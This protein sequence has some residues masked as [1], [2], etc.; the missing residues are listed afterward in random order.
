MHKYQSGFGSHFATEAIPGT[1][2]NGQNSPQRH[3]LGLYTEQFSATAFTMPRHK[4][5][6]SW[7]YRI[8]PSVK[9]GCFK[10]IIRNKN[11]LSA[12]ILHETPPNAMRWDRLDELTHPADFIEGL[13]SL[14][15][16]GD[17]TSMAG[18]AI[19]IYR[20]NK[21]MEKFFYNSDGEMV[22]VPESGRLLIRT[23]MGNLEIEPLEIVVIPR[24]IKFQVLLLDKRID[25]NSYGYVCENYGAPFQ[26][27]DLGPIGA[28]GLANPR[29]FEY[30]VASFEDLAG[31]F[32]LTCKL[33]GELWETHIK[34]SPFDV[35]AWHGN[36]SPYKYDLRKYNTIGSISFDHPDPSI[37]TVLTSPTDTPGMANIDFVIFPPRWMVAENT[38]RPPWYHRNVMSEFMGL[39][40]GQYDAKPNGFVTGGSSIHNRMVPHGPDSEAAI[41]A[42][43]EVLEPKHYENTMAFMFESSKTWKVTEFALHDKS[44]QDSYMECWQDIP[45]LFVG[46]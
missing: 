44:Y 27:P 18:A 11:F 5:I 46:A 39:L 30:P 8:H 34:H 6:R 41:K 45:K 40:Q 31:D 37:F 26:L 25:K 29:D 32:I 21:S 38:F 28:N 19:H 10:K 15:L 14:A 16:N 22:I 7:L 33:E 35:V 36:C 42:M 3:H 9:T 17:V 20:A 4:N 23:E 13:T 2:P 1:L 12:P 43:S 24:G